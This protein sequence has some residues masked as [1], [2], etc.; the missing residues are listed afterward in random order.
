MYITRIESFGKSKIK[1][2]IDEEY[3]FWI[4]KRE[5]DKYSIREDIEISEAE[6]DELAALN[7]LRAKK[8]VMNLLKR[9]DKTRQ[10][11]IRKLKTSGYNED[12]I[13][14]TLE[15]IDSF[16]YIDDNKYARKYVGYK[17]DTKSKKE[18]Q[19]L[20]FIKGVDKDIIEQAIIEEYGSEEVAIKKAIAKRARG[21]K[22]LSDDDK[23][24]IANSLYNKGFEHG[25]IRKSLDSSL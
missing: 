18:I 9:M 19:N 13:V 2:H 3:K 8:Q 20:L 22:E 24:K 16:N 5:V 7:L 11:V 4:Y 12:I 1:I 23:R 25:L 10:E 14:D 21:K 6:Y 15:Y 17:R